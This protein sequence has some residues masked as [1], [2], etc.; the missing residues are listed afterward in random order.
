MELNNNR[1]VVGII[2][3][4]RGDPPYISVGKLWNETMAII[5]ERFH[6][7]ILEV[8]SYKVENNE[9]YHKFIDKT[10]VLMTLSPYYYINRNIKKFPLVA[11]GLGSMQ[12]G[13]HWLYDN[14][15]SFR[16]YDSIILNCTSC[17]NIFNKLAD[18]NNI[19]SSLIPFG[20]DTSVFYP[21]LN[22]SELRDKYNIPQ[23][24]FIML[25]CGRI[26]LQKNVHL[27]ISL[28]RDL[29]KKYKNL[30]L[31]IIGSYDDF[32]IPEFSYKDAPDVKK[33]FND[34]ICRFDLMS[35]VII[36]ENQSNPENYAELINTADIGINLTTLI[37][38]N[39]GYTP[40]EMQACGLPV[41]GADWG[42]LKDT[43]K[44]GYSGYKIQTILSRYGPRVNLEQA[45]NR[46]EK[47]INDK[48]CL[49]S[50]KENA[51]KNSEINYSLDSFSGNI[52]NIISE[53]Y[54]RFKKMSDK[55][56]SQLQV[57]S[58]LKDMSSSIR[59]FIGSDRHVSWEHLHPK[60]DIN[61]YYLFAQECA[62]AKSEHLIWNNKSIVSKGFDW[63][64]I[65]G[66]FFSHDPRWNQS[67][68]LE[69]LC[70]NKEEINFLKLA[71]NGITVHDLYL[72]CNGM[73]DD[74]DSLLKV[75]TIKG[76]IM[77]FNKT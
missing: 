16:S 77:P 28:L 42:G 36:F 21:R 44:D 19:K 8:D 58:I 51:R 30:Y 5:S 17:Q 52:Q 66:K 27:L 50:M 32:Y 57:N 7:E 4:K 31:M 2:F 18:K 39:F 14:R 24:A 43:I 11:Y 10:D 23:D 20:I 61:H 15:D 76:F 49:E 59:K 1:P 48:S 70:L 12:K 53:T 37:S 45:K 67:F 54:E 62:S 47:L 74:I 63:E 40:V 35:K 29:E 56:D 38:E 73:F 72:T 33:E 9:K 22:K 55:N 25:Y 41:I 34:L 68:E 13:G 65:N 3:D 26:N 6:T 64:I 46:I 75:L 71:E 69:D 60:L